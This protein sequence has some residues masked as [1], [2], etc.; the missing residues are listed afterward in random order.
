VVVSVREDPLCD[1]F[2]QEFP[3][4]LQEADRSVGFQEGVVRFVGFGEN[5]NNSLVPQM[6]PK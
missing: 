2:L 5:N 3:T 1:D 4:A 6:V